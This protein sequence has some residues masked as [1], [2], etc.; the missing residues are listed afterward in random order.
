MPK[1][2]AVHTMPM[3]VTAEEVTPLV[4]ELLKSE[5]RDAYWVSAW[6]QQN[7]EGKFLKFFCEWNAKSAD[8][9]RKLFSFVPQ[10][11]LDGVYPMARIESEDFR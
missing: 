3:P 4:K 5:T 11:P 10:F 2:L 1:F 8:A 7:T 9:I 6:G